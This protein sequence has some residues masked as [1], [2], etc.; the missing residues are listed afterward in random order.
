MS[1][2]WR[3]EH[4]GHERDN[5]RWRRVLPTGSF[6]AG[7]YHPGVRGCSPDVRSVC[8]TRGTD[9]RTDCVNPYVP[10]PYAPHKETP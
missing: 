3:D 10:K 9:C 2:S 6:P 7:A 5:G 1:T 8:P 4:A